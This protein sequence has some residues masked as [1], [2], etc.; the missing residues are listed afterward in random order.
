MSHQSDCERSI[1]R[2]YEQ[3]LTDIGAV[4]SAYADAAHLCDAMAKDIVESNRKGKRQAR[5]DI[6]Q[7]AEQITLV[8][9]AIFALRDKVNRSNVEEP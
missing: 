7:L 8:G 2:Y 4:R 9:N 6:Q 5:K 1:Q 3:S